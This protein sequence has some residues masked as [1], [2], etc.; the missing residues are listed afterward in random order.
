MRKREQ[1]GNGDCKEVNREFLRAMP[2][3]DQLYVLVGAESDWH[4]MNKA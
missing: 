2:S 3:D 4:W 1:F